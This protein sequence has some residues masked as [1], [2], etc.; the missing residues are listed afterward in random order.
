[1]KTKWNNLM[2]RN[3]DE[4]DLME[5]DYYGN[6]GCGVFKQRGT[7]LEFFCIGINIPKGN[8]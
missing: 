4:N 6:T 7:K 2:E 1:M 3:H 5:I 8:C